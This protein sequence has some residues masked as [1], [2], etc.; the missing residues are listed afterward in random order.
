MPTENGRGRASSQPHRGSQAALTRV[1][2]QT[3]A[4]T[5][6][7]SGNGQKGETN[8]RAEAGASGLTP[9]VRP[10]VA[11]TMETPVK[12]SPPSPFHASSPGSP[13]LGGSS[14]E[15]KMSHRNPEAIRLLKATVSG[16]AIGSQSDR[17]GSS[18]ARGGKQ[19]RHKAIW[20]KG[21]TPRKKED[22]TMPGVRKPVAGPSVSQEESLA[23]LHL[24]REYEEKL[25]RAQKAIQQRDNEIEGMLQAHERKGAMLAEA[26]KR[27]ELTRLRREHQKE[28]SNHERIHRAY[29]EEKMNNEARAMHAAAG[30][31]EQIKAA[32]AEAKAEA[33][34]RRREA[35]A[36][37]GEARA[38][39][40]RPRG[41]L[42]PPRR[43][44]STLVEQKKREHA[45]AEKPAGARGGEE[46]RGG[47]ADARA[48]ARQGEGGGAEEGGGGGDPRAE[49]GHPDGARQG[50]EPTAHARAGGGDA[51]GGGQPALS[52]ADDIPA[53]D[54]GDQGGGGGE[55]T[56]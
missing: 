28:L 11:G 24:R 25:D 31:R 39:V 27:E 51:N 40:A 38:A 35:E 43:R 20:S 56:G 14:S 13:P 22:E 8:W 3:A 33:G 36:A 30:Q 26:E 23:V 44:G 50:G 52:A 10:S 47:R 55:A 21:G 42:R 12:G 32:R 48:E 46:R 19:A 16:G 45:R 18:S 2:V 37:R 9:L 41:G 6:P 53:R 49:C 7:N 54:A 29:E 17:T 5:S 15:R 4:R 34:D 1:R